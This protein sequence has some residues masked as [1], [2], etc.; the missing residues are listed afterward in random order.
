MSG[1]PIM[2]AEC[3]VLHGNHQPSCGRQEWENFKRRLNAIMREITTED[4]HRV[5]SRILWEAQAEAFK[6]FSPKIAA[7]FMAAMGEEYNV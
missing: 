5:R 1:N 4:P 7:E 6:R 2:C 3:G